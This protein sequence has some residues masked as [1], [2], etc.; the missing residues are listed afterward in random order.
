MAQ[1]SQRAYIILNARGTRIT[2]T[3]VTL[4]VLALPSTFF[5]SLDL[6]SGSESEEIFLDHDPLAVAAVLNA[7][8]NM[9]FSTVEALAAIRHTSQQNPYGLRPLL[10]FL[11]LAWM[12]GQHFASCFDDSRLCQV[13][14]KGLARHEF[15]GQP[16]DVL[17]H[18]AETYQRPLSASPES[19]TRRWYQLH[20]I[21]LV[22]EQVELFGLGD[23]A[24][25]LERG[26]LDPRHCGY[27]PLGE[28]RFWDLP[29]REER[30]WPSAPQSRLVVD[31]GQGHAVWPTGVS[32]TLSVPDL[33]I[34]QE[35][36]LA[37]QLEGSTEFEEQNQMLAS[38]HFEVPGAEMAEPACYLIHLPVLPQRRSAFRMLRLSATMQ[39]KR[40]GCVSLQ[41]FGDLLQDLPKELLTHVKAPHMFST[42]YTK[43]DRVGR[44]KTPYHGAALGECTFRKRG[45]LPRV[46]LSSAACHR[47]RPFEVPHAAN[48]AGGARG[49]VKL[50]V[51]RLP[52]ETTS[53]LLHRAF[54]HY[55]E[56]LEVFLIDGRGASGARC[57]FVRLGDLQEK[58]R[59]LGSAD[60]RKSKSKSRSASHESGWSRYTIEGKG[61][62]RH[63][64]GRKRSSRR[65][66]RDKKRSRSRKKK[67]SRSSRSDSSKGRSDSRSS[68][69]SSKSRS[70]SRSKRRKD[71]SHKGRERHRD[72]EKEAM[73]PPPMGWPG[74][75]FMPMPGMPPMMPPWAM[76]WAMP[77]M[78]GF[79]FDSEEAERQLR[80]AEKAA[81]K[82]EQRRQKE[83]EEIDKAQVWEDHPARMA[84]KKSKSRSSSSSRGRRA[85]GKD[86]ARGKS[87]KSRKRSRSSSKR[88]SRRHGKASGAAVSPMG[89]PGPFLGYGALAN[90]ATAPAKVKEAVE[91]KDGDSGDSD[92]D[93]SKVEAEI[94]FADI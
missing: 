17:Q 2:T 28:A 45:L 10:H 36:G 47:C 82:E 54:E 73:P 51:G 16:P 49:G 23:E 5:G 91:E 27:I 43:Y 37:V 61:R 25:L 55:G 34:S 70:C 38:A 62:S 42:T 50:F 85:K 18:L 67:A 88:R 58:G 32:V 66:R 33:L 35:E 39:D 48:A 71:R 8:A 59:G 24:F 90:M 84:Q 93:M 41:I 40:V 20:Q 72:R 26:A 69:K 63:S 30:H 56:V 11:G 9:R 14:C 78:E 19:G 3:A 80:K 7:F 75:P 68:S 12:Q 86:K 6:E 57:A 87:S 79:P 94:N 21:A 4:G 64:R 53:D 1:V 76:P 74:P 31:L 65:K 81:K 92:V 46:D 29:E 13:T 77:G 22:D 15:V 60:S 83:E 52:V 44:G 89:W